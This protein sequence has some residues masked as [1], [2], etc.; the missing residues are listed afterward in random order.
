MERETDRLSAEGMRGDI[1]AA[2]TRLDQGERDVLVLVAAGGLGYE[3][4][5]QALGVA[6]GTVL[7]PQSG[8]GEDASGAGG[9]QWMSWR[10]SGAGTTASARL[11]RRPWTPPRRALRRRTSGAR[12]RPAGPQN[13]AAVRRRRDGHRRDRDG[14][15]LEPATR[16]PRTAGRQRGGTWPGR[17][18]PT[19]GRAGR[20]RPAAPVVVRQDGDARWGRQTA[21]DSFPGSAWTGSGAGGPIGSRAERDGVDG[22]VRSARRGPRAALHRGRP[23]QEAAPGRDR[24]TVYAAGSPTHRAIRRCSAWRSCCSR[25]TTCRLASRP[26]CTERCP[27]CR[28]SACYR[29]RRTRPTHGVALFVVAGALRTELI[30]TAAPTATSAPATSSSMTARPGLRG[31]KLFTGRRSCRPRSS[32]DPEN[33]REDHFV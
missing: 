17:P 10:P 20:H 21:G 18:R 30:L 16:I 25:T 27:G 31:P 5:A 24:A 15:D 7:A 12:V 32:N 13:G 33:V 28:A 3:E 22:A 11:G 14:P 26:R 29:T 1:A 19:R 9:P 23:P 8:Q 6:V 4:I 2:L